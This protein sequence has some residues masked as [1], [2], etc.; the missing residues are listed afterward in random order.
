MKDLPDSNDALV[1][2]IDFSDDAAWARVRTEIEA[3]AGEFRAYVSFVSDP[4]FAGLSISALTS[5]AQRGPYRSFMF[6]VDRLSLTEPE[7]PILVLDLADKPGRTFRVVPREIW[8]VE[9]NLSIANMDFE[10]F[11]DSADA[12]GVFRGFPEA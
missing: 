6:I 8:G 11:A 12:D 3:P 10:E 5:I 7:H 4:A 9:N 2:R 1:V